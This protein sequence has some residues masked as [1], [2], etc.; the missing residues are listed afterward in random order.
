[1][2]QTSSHVSGVAER[3]AARL[4]PY[5]QPVRL[6]AHWNALYRAV[7]RIDVVDDVVEPA[8][9]PELF[10]VH[11]DIAHIGATA[12]RD[13]PGVL[14]LAGREVENHDAALAV[15]LAA[16]RVR[17]A[18]GDVQLLAVAAWVEPVRADPGPDEVGL[19]E[20]VAIDDVDAVGMHIGNIKARA[21]G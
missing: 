20:A 11:A 16:R 9:Q 6:L 7:R 10:S 21:V 18:V 12:A 4:R 15:R 17:A 2:T 13:R 1:M 14:D 19:R 8:G 5:R 3:V